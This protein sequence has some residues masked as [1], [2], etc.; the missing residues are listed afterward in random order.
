MGEAEG[1]REE[2]GRG[3]ESYHHF[4][5]LLAGFAFIAIHVFLGEHFL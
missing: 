2:E 1:G 3:G 5:A 4:N